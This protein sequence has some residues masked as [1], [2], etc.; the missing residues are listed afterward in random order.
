MK[1]NYLLVM[2]R[3]VECIGD[4]YVFPLGMSYISSNMK[5]AGFNVYTVNLSHK[6]EDPK[7]VLKALIQKHN[8][9]VVGTGGLSP[10]YHMVKNVIEEVKEINPNFFRFVMSLFSFF[11]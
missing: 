9:H 5:A 8:I 11:F 1:L 2:P 10:Q 3:L 4:G 7:D 6:E